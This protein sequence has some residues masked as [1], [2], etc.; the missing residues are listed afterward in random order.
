MGV[1]V[2]NIADIQVVT[3]LRQRNGIKAIDIGSG[4]ARYLSD[5]NIGADQGLTIAFIFKVST[6]RELL[7]LTKGG[8]G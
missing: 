4:A 3:T 2:T 6:D 5:K 8:Q 1:A 7:C